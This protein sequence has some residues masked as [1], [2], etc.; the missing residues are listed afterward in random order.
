[1]HLGILG[2]AYTYSKKFLTKRTFQVQINNTLCDTPPLQITHVTP[3][4]RA[5][6]RT[7]FDIATCDL[8]T[9][10]NDTNTKFPQFA[11]D[12]SICHA[13]KDEKY[14]QKSLQQ[15]LDQ[16]EIWTDTWGLDFV[17]QQKPLI[18]N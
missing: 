8:D 14:L 3:Q 15:A 1:M 11:D 2:H 12:T 16:L 4:G 9:T 7:H 6:S 17:Q 5:L 18:L 13:H 10:T